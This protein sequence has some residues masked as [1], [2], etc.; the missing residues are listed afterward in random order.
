MSKHEQ[1]TKQEEQRLFQQFL[2]D[3]QLFRQEAAARD[4]VIALN[5]GRMM[6]EENQA[7]RG[8]Q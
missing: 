1:I 6:G 8:K 5:V 3:T 4:I 2:K 7:Y